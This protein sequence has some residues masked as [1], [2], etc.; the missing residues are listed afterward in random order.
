MAISPYQTASLIGPIRVHTLATCQLEAPLHY[1]CDPSRCIVYQTLLNQ[2]PRF[3]IFDFPR[4]EGIA[5]AVSLGN[6]LLKFYIM[7]SLP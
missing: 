3:S 5:N 2:S 6:M 7:Q 4:L 1:S